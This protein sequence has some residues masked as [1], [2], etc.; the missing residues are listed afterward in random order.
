MLGVNAAGDFKLRPMLNYYYENSKALY[1]YEVSLNFFLIANYTEFLGLTEK[2][3]LKKF[4]KK[5]YL[6]NLAKGNC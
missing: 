2:E 1:K 5:M 4:K 3:V 6:L